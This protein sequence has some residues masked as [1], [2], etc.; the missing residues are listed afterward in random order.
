MPT[1]LRV[2]PGKDNRAIQTAIDK[3]HARGG[4]TVI[5]PKGVY[6][7]LDAVHLR[8]GVNLRG[9]PGAVLLNV[10]NIDMVIPHYVGYGMTEFTVAEPK[11]LRVGMGIH[12]FDKNSFGFYTTVGT[13]LRINGDRVII[14][15]RLSHDYNAANGAMA[16]TVH[17]VIEGDGVED[18]TVEGLT[19][20]GNG[21]KMTRSLNGCRG[22]GLFLIGC[23]RVVI[24]DTEI[25]NYH[26]DALSFQQSTD[27]I[28]D[29][30]HVHHNTGGGLHP[31]SGSVRYI[32]QNNDVHDNGSFGL[33]YCL[34]TS[35]S[36]TRNNKLHHNGQ[37]GISVGERDTHH[38]IEGN[39]VHDN[40]G[41]AVEFRPPLKEGGDF[42]QLLGNT[43][44]NNCAKRANAE[45][46]IPAGL[47]EVHLAGNTFS[48]RVGV[49][50][51][52]EV[53]AGAADISAIDNTVDGRSQQADD[54]VI[55]Q[56]LP[57]DAPDL[58][59]SGK[60]SDRKLPPVKGNATHVSLKKPRK[61]TPIGPA[62]IALDGAEHLDVP[63]LAPWSAWAK[64]VLRKEAV[65]QFARRSSLERV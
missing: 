17:S 5:V 7:C 4:G 44:R 63:K 43:F 50:R 47:N 9:E 25:R 15:R 49:A 51:A 29:H 6:K 59:E 62:A 20:D 32:L 42:V 40:A 30:C 22:G 55:P 53:K 19:L 18:C 21:G 14:N 56:D 28:V 26:G 10:P 23:H 12:V 52:V 13:I 37:A 54:F 35:H 64:K 61:L 31:G 27:I 34:R 46:V 38:H 41:P 65:S 45:V 36:I 16:S 11:K 60:A 24:R 2:G 48:L 39:E 33:F 1:T 58:W 57:S 3:L 8:T